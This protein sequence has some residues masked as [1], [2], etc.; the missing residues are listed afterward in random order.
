ML[1]SGALRHANHFTGRTTRWKGKLGSLQRWTV[2]PPTL[3]RTAR[4][5][6][7]GTRLVSSPHCG[8]DLAGGGD[9]GVYVFGGVRGAEEGGLELRRG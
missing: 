9:G 3:R 6:G 7:G 2:S 1:A 5:E 4:R 8:K